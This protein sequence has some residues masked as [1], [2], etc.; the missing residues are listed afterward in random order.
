MKISNEKCPVYDR[1]VAKF[2]P[3]PDTTVF[4]YGDTIYAKYELSVDLQVHEY[5]HSLQQIEIGGTEIWWDRY[6]S[7]DKFRFEQ[8]VAAYQAQHRFLKDNIK[9]RN[10]LAKERIRLAKD[11]SSEIYGN[12]IDYSAAL[13]VIKK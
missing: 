11:L 10:K 8:E 4:C 7:D 9:D 3:L 1:C 5:V 12:M 2:G 6:L 13:K